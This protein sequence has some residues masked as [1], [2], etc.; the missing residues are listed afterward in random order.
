MCQCNTGY[1]APDCQLAD[2]SLFENCSGHGVCTQPGVCTCNGKLVTIKSFNTKKAVTQAEIAAKNQNPTLL[3]ESQSVI[4][5]LNFFSL[6]GATV[7][8]AALIG[9]IVAG[10]LFARRWRRKRKMRFI[11]PPY[12]PAVFGRYMDMLYDTKGKDLS[13]LEPF[14]KMLHR[15]GF[16]L[17]LAISNAVA[18][19]DREGVSRSL[20]HTL[21]AGDEDLIPL[22]TKLIDSEVAKAESEK[23]MRMKILIFLR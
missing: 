9:A 1:L 17:A 11:E 10:G 22:M 12:T 8:G 23:K 7:G 20:V 14:S 18:A 6:S 21:A 5:I 4:S 3:S 16:D 13:Y 15:T 19:T 2:C